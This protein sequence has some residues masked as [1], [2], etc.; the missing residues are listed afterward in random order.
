[1]EELFDCRLLLYW[2]KP[3]SEFRLGPVFLICS[4]FLKRDRNYQYIIFKKVRVF[5]IIEVYL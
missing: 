2:L 1:M 5:T 4:V 3:F